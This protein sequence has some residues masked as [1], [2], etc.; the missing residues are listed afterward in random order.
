[1]VNKTWIDWP[2]YVWSPMCVHVK[3]T[4]VMFQTLGFISLLTKFNN[5]QT[6]NHLL[7]S[8]N[9]LNFQYL[10]LVIN[11]TGRW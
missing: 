11:S 3:Q 9:M 4:F 1:M 5:M 8:K 10:L 2:Y 7:L 6:Y